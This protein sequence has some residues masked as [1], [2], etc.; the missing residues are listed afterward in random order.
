MFDGSR[1][2]GTVALAVTFSARDGHHLDLRRAAQENAAASREL[3]PGCVQFDLVQLEEPGEFLF[4]EQFTDAAA[5]EAHFD[6]DHYRRWRRAVERHVVP[7]SMIKKM[8][9]LRNHDD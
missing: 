4:C 6:T 2:A 5:F 3:E 1:P 8:G 7:G 9:R